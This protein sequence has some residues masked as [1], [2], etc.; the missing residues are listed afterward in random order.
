MKRWIKRIGLIIMIPVV[1][2]VLLAVLLY[3][4]S[5]QNFAKN[6]AT[7]ALSKATGMDIR[8]DRVRLSFPL[9]LV[10]QEVEV[11]SADADT[12]LHAGEISASVKLLPLF[13]KEVVVN[14]ADIRDVLVDSDSLIK[15]MKIKGVVGNLSLK[16][17]R[18]LLTEEQVTINDISLSDTDLFLC[19]ND[20]APEVKD[21]VQTPIQWKLDLESVALDRVSFAL[22]MPSDSLRLFTRVDKARLKDGKIDLD[23]QRYE[24]AKVTFS[25]SSFAFS[26]GDT[27]ALSGFD[28]SHIALSDVEIEL[29]SVSNQQME[30][31]AF[32]RRLSFKERSGLEV[33]SLTGQVRMDSTRIDVP[34][35]ELT[36]PYSNISLAASGAVNS[37]SKQ[38]EGDIKAKLIASLG[39]KDVLI[40]AGQLPEDFKTAYPNQPVSV[41]VDI[42]GNV[43]KLYIRT[44]DARL[45]DAFKLTAS[46]NAEALDDSIRRAGEL[47]LDLTTGNLDF[48]K[49]MLDSTARGQFTLPSHMTVTGDATLAAGLY[50]AQLN[51]TEDSG[52]V[53]LT[54]RYQMA[55]QSY[56]ADLEIHNLQLQ[57]FLPYDSLQTLTAT[58]KAEGQGT[59]F[60]SPATSATVQ[61]TINRLQYGSLNLSGVTLDASLKKNRASATLAST[62]APAVFVM[63][64]KGVLQRNHVTA[65]LDLDAKHLDLYQL[66]LMKSPFSTAFALRFTGESDMQK[67]FRAQANLNQWSIVTPKQTVYPKNISLQALS[68]TKQTRLDIQAGDLDIEMTGNEDVQALS[69]KFSR[70]SEALTEQMKQEMLN[71]DELRSL[72]P[73]LQVHIAAGSDNPV[74]NFLGLTGMNFKAMSLNATTSPATGIDGNLLVNTLQVDTL[75]LDT[76]RFALRQ[77][78]AEILLDGGVINNE[79]NRQHVFTA[80]VD[81]AVHNSGA[82][83]LLK[84]I[85]GQGKTGLMLGA[86]VKREDKSWVASFYPDDPVLAF[87]RFHLIS[88]NYIRLGDNKKIDARFRMEGEDG[89]VL[90]FNTRPSD[91]KQN[92][93]DLGIQKFNLSL[94][95]QL[96]PYMPDVGGLLHADVE[97]ATVDSTY[98][99]K[100]NVG[101]DTLSYERGLLGDIQLNASYMPGGNKSH[102]IDAH[103][104]HDKKEVLTASGAYYQAGGRDSLQS[105]VQVT[106]LPLRI[107]NP[108]IPQ[109]MANV[110]GAADGRLT[111]TGNMMHPRING[112]VHLDTASVFVVP[113]GA[114]F[115]FD[116]KQIA[117]KD[118]RFLFDHYAIL[119]SGKNPF[120]IDG[121]VDASD[122]SRMT[123]DLVLSANNM[124]VLNVKRNKESLVYGK[125]YIDM[126]T[127]VKGPVDALVMRG[128]IDLLGN[129]NVTYVM[130]DSP[131]TVQDRLSDIVTFVNFADTAQLKKA[132]EPPLQLG[133]LNM[134]VTIHIDPAVQL[135]V[136]LSEDRQSYANVE[137]GGDLSFQYSPQGDMILTGRYTINSGTVRY[138]L[139][140][141]PAKTFS[142]REGSYVEWTGNLADPYLD[143][144]AIERVRTSVSLADQAPQLVN[145]DVSISV[146][147]TLENLSLQF[148]LSAPE[149]MAVENELSAMSAEERGKQA[150]SMLVTNMY[151][152]G[153]SN[154]KTNVNVGSALNSFLQKEIGNLAGSALKTIDVSFGMESYDQDGQAG[155]AQRTDYS[156]Q[157]SKR[158]YNDRIRVIVGGRIST[159]LPEEETQSFIDNVSLEYRL[160]S[161]GSR[162]I[163]LFHNKDYESILEG[164]ITET[165][166]GLVLRRKM[167]RLK[168]L[169]LFKKKQQNQSSAL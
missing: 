12:L 5:V 156:F 130:K 134:L 96:L 23:L 83:V 98:H 93:L 62:F 15:G 165:G 110:A 151:M 167:Q 86:R 121:V 7:A 81:G 115:R 46:G 116:D 82:E 168:E 76:V 100:A 77:Q 67:T 163:K 155:G 13:K 158:F 59:D 38:P 80:S 92:I 34:G 49:A 142:I 120:V 117:V 66:H 102:Y 128:N 107:A 133:G 28:P 57:H 90:S 75:Q 146:K 137:G 162:Y 64:L 31:A 30:V 126:Q 143:V 21:T 63:N 105:R 53:D 8:I 153:G 40:L 106:S 91:A 111:V 50:R 55:Q 44:F 14:G 160:D 65:D 125:V 79:Q 85:N 39:K 19:L 25:G 127:T 33:T 94:L 122:I 4:P 136:D 42:D 47:K 70:F 113:A 147:N 48:L 74:H 41:Q 124:E 123:A 1:L 36:T 132:E 11:V 9:N 108:F 56:G 43:Q 2:F 61:G 6:K 51:L 131:L 68:E 71:L 16:A 129:T 140:V 169:F 103:L 52:T 152:A 60:F 109:D 89:A 45:A 72:L 99:V 27:V 58:V 87:R 32:I 3:I 78:G 138:A 145:F 154:G 73:G 69:T 17:D 18:A 157:F 166:A 35:L 141:V 150:I 37:F 114:R 164:E 10:I 97:Y 118:S 104:L 29:D 112:Y 84:F 159:G 22:N 54:A 26:R 95:S 20:T 148:N 149:N 161:S 139:P 24:A 135:N 88:N 119:T 144:T 101:I